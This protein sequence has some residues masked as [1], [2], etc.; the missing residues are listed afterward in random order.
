MSLA[1]AVAL[2]GLA[3]GLGLTA[4]A[5][6]PPGSRHP[7]SRAATNSPTASHAF[8]MSLVGQTDRERAQD[9]P[10]REF[11]LRLRRTRSEALSG[12]RLRV[13]SPLGWALDRVLPEP[14]A[15]GEAV[16]ITFEIEPAPGLSSICAQVFGRIPD[17]PSAA[18][19]H[20]SDR[21][22]FDPSH[23]DTAAS[24]GKEP[25]R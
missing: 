22:C 23:P 2:G 16:E 3:V 6:L 21:L 10:T 12:P 7:A 4:A 1:K 14:M 15:P 25:T 20:G 18:L 17:L 9:N 11:R 8:E 5:L 24:R 13:R 19:V